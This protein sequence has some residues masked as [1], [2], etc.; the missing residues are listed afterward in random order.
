MRLEDA[1]C[2]PV[3]MFCYPKGRFNR[4][5]IRHVKQAG[6]KGAR[7]TRM[8][9]QGLDFDPFQMPTSLLAHP[10]IRMLYAKNL[11]K[12]WNI[13]GLFDYVT[14]FMSLDSWTAIGK[15]LFDR[16][17]REGGVWHLYGHSWEI[18]KNGLWDELKEILDY[19]SRREGVFYAS[20]V[21]VLHLRARPPQ[22]V[23]KRATGGLQL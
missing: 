17:L 3:Q 2:A 8:V 21:D 13:R 12:S 11:A 5:V 20:N 19:V 4:C 22:E 9:R 18:E 14:Q 6:Y 16:V 15:I 1:L 10:N 23:E 7:T